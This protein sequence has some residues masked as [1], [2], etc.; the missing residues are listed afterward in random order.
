MGSFFQ[1]QIDTS[2]VSLA[3]WW[4][5]N[6]FFAQKIASESGRAWLF[7]GFA[8]LSIGIHSA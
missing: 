8:L 5:L 2:K 4:N 1:Y 6:G 3:D 7:L